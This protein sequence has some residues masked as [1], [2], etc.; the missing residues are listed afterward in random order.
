VDVLG[1]EGRLEEREADP[2]LDGPELP[3]EHADLREDAAGVLVDQR[4]GEPRAADGGRRREELRRERQ[5]ALGVVAPSLTP[6]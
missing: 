4:L 2:E 1:I 3:Q 6:S 5:E